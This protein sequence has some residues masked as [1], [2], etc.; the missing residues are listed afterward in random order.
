[1]GRTGLAL[2]EAVSDAFNLTSEWELLR[3]NH[4]TTL[5]RYPAVSTWIDEYDSHP[6]RSDNGVVSPVDYEL[7]CATRPA[8]QRDVKQP[9]D[10]RPASSTSRRLRRP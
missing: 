6:R 1:M 7:A 5:S 8:P 3:H 10:A 4:F 2:D 9:G